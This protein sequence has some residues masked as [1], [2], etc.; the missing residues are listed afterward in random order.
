MAR[1]SVSDIRIRPY[2]PQDRDAIVRLSLRAWA[3]VFA[4]LEQALDP[5]VHRAFYPDGWQA[6]QRK[7]VGAACDDPTLH[8][9]VAE[10]GGRPAGFVAVRLHDEN[11]MGEIHMV[12]VDPDHQHQG[13][14]RAL[15]A[16][17]LGWMREA[18]MKV[19]MVETGGDPGHGAARRTYEQA[20]FRVLPVARYFKAL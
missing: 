18:G 13:I 17:A 3:P 6:S 19:A 5:D 1:R 2:D 9:Q 7:A 14:G 11:S 15:T 16:F 8:V 20:G 10:C 12:A 4:S